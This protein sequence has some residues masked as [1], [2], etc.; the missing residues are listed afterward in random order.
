M[1]GMKSY[2]VK[3][4][5]GIIY[6]GLTTTVG[7]TV[8]AVYHLIL[9]GVTVPLRILLL[10]CAVFFGIYVARLIFFYSLRIEVGADTVNLSR[11]RQHWVFKKS[12]IKLTKVSSNGF[13][14]I[15]ELTANGQKF[16]VDENFTNAS[17][18]VEE[19][20]DVPPG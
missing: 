20:S 13:Q 6:V 15:F 8:V 1:Q 10:V 16:R 11:F 2:R 19:L 18:L 7:L 3:A 9:H 14:R 5:P 17:R 12:D 4:G